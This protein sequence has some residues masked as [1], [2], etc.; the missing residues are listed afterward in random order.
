[1]Y[2]TERLANPTANIYLNFKIYWYNKYIIFR[3]C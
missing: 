2:Y 1:M 3:L